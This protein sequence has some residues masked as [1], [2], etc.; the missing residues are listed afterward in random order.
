MRPQTF[1]L[2]C[3]TMANK[4]PP[5]VTAEELALLN[6][7]L[8]ALIRALAIRAARDDHQAALQQTPKKPIRQRKKRRLRLV[9]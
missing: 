1:G 5:S 8:D 6:E 2:N 9:K 7:G 3:V 4:R